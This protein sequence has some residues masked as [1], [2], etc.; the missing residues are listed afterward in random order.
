MKKMLLSLLLCTCVSCSASAQDLCQQDFSGVTLSQS[1]EDA[2]KAWQA[3]GFTQKTD[4]RSIGPSVTASFTPPA[5]QSDHMKQIIWT[6][7][8]K[9]DRNT[10]YKSK[11]YH[12]ITITYGLNASKSDKESFIN[13]QKETLLNYCKTMPG[14]IWNTANEK[15][16]VH[17]SL[18][19]QDI[20]MARVTKKLCDEAQAG[21]FP[22]DKDGFVVLPTM[23][24]AVKRDWHKPGCFITF[25]KAVRNH[26]F[27]IEYQSQVTDIQ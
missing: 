11:S 18:R 16:T 19:V 15:V 2:I 6:E 5:E 24:S 27:T 25:Q 9:N 20:S 17:N 26:G 1:K 12:S 8:H 21:T 23:Y 7:K 22:M 13:L 3:H 4:P 10:Q 14:Y